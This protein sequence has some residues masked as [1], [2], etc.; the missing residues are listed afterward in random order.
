MCTPVRAHH[1][2]AWTQCPPQILLL[3]AQRPAALLDQC[4]SLAGCPSSVAHPA[5]CAAAVADLVAVAADNNDGV[6]LLLQSPRWP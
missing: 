6:V 3:P 4:T 1:Q 5:Q 2:H